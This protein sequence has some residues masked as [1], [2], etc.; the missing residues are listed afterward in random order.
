[1]IIRNF[2]LLF[3]LLQFVSRT[4]LAQAE[5]PDDRDFMEVFREVIAE[6]RQ[7]DFA[8]VFRAKIWQDEDGSLIKEISKDP[9]L[10]SAIFFH[11]D[12]VPEKYAVIVL[13]SW[14]EDDFQ[15]GARGGSYYSPA[16][17]FEHWLR[18]HMK[19]SDADEPPSGGNMYFVLENKETR[20]ELAKILRESYSEKDLLPEERKIRRSAAWAGIMEIVSDAYPR[21]LEEDKERRANADTGSRE[22][23]ENF[24]KNIRIEENMPSDLS[25]KSSAPQKATED[26]FASSS[27][28]SIST[29]QWGLTLI[30]ILVAAV[31]LWWFLH[32]KMPGKL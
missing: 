17:P 30:L 29:I 19:P 6:G 20:Q 7:L 23:A 22:Q 32:D 27:E 8:E 28:Q 10:N 12:A 3:L 26:H 13:A 14:L 2:L 21:L 25:V 5:V 4:S 15:W 9:D 31:L 18:F 11:L 1:M 24:L 16:G